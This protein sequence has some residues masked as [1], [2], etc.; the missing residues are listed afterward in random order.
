MAASSREKVSISARVGIAARILHDQILEAVL[1]GVLGFWVRGSV[2][3]LP[4]ALNPIHAW[5]KIRWRVYV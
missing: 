1:A 5:S 2:N 3:G 4:L